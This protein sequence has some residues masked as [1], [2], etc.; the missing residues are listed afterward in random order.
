MAITLE[1]RPGALG[2]R[3]RNKTAKTFQYHYITPNR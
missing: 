2:G 3:L 1:I